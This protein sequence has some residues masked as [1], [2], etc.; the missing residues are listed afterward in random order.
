MYVRVVGA[1]R[2]FNNARSLTAFSVRPVK[3]FNEVTQHNLEVIKCHLENVRGRPSGNGMQQQAPSF[4]AGPMAMAGGYSAPQQQQGVGIQQQPQQPMPQISMANI[5]G[6]ENAPNPQ[7]NLVR[8]AGRFR[9]LLAHT[10]NASLCPMYSG[11]LGV[12]ARWSG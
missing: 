8:S 1:L 9:C 10:Y 11:F 3:D 4:N 6:L 5:P 7:Y 12:P 2:S